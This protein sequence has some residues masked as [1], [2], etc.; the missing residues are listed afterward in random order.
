MYDEIILIYNKGQGK[1]KLKLKLKEYYN[2]KIIGCYR[3]IYKRDV[4][5]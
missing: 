1:S 5:K 3:T 4:K 2:D